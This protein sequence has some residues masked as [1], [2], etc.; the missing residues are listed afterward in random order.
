MQIRHEKI[1]KMLYLCR[2]IDRERRDLARMMKY[3]S[4]RSAKD[5]SSAHFNL[6]D[7]HRYDKVCFHL[8]IIWLLRD[9]AI[10]L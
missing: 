10:E 2:E 5:N 3:R 1:H 4:R 7:Y 6:I 8:M 9:D